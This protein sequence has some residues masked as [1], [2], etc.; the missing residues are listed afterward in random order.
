MGTLYP[1]ERFK[2]W[3]EHKT[4][5]FPRL[6][7]SYETSPLA[8]LDL[9]QGPKEIGRLDTNFAHEQ[10]KLFGWIFN[11]RRSLTQVRETIY[12]SIE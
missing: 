2:M 5:T 3:I 11:V 4:R 12:N 10:E 7:E 6:F 1:K 9:F 8:L